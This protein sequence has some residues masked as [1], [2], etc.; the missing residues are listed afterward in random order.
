MASF[1]GQ[2]FIVLNVV[3]NRRTWH[4]VYNIFFL[5]FFLSHSLHEFI[6]KKINKILIGQIMVNSVANI[7]I[8]VS[9]IIHIKQQSAQLQSV[10]ATPA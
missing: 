2:I 7:D 1:V 8:F 4:F 9:I 3:W 6:C 5:L 10:L